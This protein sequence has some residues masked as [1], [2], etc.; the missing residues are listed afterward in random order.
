M[1][2]EI[3]LNELPDFNLNKL[4]RPGQLSEKNIQEMVGTL[5]S[6]KLMDQLS[7]LLQELPEQRD[8]LIEKICSDPQIEQSSRLN[9]KTEQVPQD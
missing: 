3:K 4:F 9:A 5:K 1:S 7:D 2:K 6:G 8:L